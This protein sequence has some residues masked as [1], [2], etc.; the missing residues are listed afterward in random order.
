MKGR[1]FSESI[2]MKTKQDKTNATPKKNVMASANQKPG[3]Y[4]FALATCG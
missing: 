4:K 1:G 3:G 2:E